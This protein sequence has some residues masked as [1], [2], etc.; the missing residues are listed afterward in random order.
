MVAD[1][2]RNEVT[3]K[4]AKEKVRKKYA[5]HNKVPSPTRL[6][7]LSSHHRH[8]LPPLVLPMRNDR[9]PHRLHGPPQLRLLSLTLAIERVDALDREASK[10]EEEG[11]IG[12]SGEREG[13]VRPH[14]AFAGAGSL[15]ELLRDADGAFDDGSVGAEKASA[16]GRRDGGRRKGTHSERPAI[17]AT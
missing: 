13:F 9:P 15:L 6:G 14:E 4:R 2:K 17:E 11:G 16:H 1:S 5:Q 8:N 12:L 10:L 7:P 3:R